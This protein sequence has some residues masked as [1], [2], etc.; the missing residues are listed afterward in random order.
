MTRS[1]DPSRPRPQRAAVRPT[2]APVFLPPAPRLVGAAHEWMERHGLSR[3]PD[4]R[5]LAAAHAG[6]E[7]APLAGL[8]PDTRIVALDWIGTHPDASDATLRAA[9]DLE[10]LA[11]STGAAVVA[12]RMAPLVGAD[13]PLM[14]WLARRPGLDARARRA[15]IQPVLE[16]DVAATLARALAGEGPRSGAFELCGPDVMNLGE[17][18]DIAAERG[19]TAFAADPVCEPSLPILRTQGMSEWRP[20]AEAFGVTPSPITAGL[21]DEVPR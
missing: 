5:I 17:L 2:R 15:L 10:E 7:Q 12:L 18:M 11:R 1:L 14:A 20:W 19:V 21:A 8:G 9:W 6:D 3:A 4:V 16:R 13:A